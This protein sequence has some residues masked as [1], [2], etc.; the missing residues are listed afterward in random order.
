MISRKM[1]GGEGGSGG[2]KQIDRNVMMM[3]IRK[4]MN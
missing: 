4:G 2:E 1:D 3:M